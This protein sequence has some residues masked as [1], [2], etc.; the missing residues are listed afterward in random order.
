MNYALCRRVLH[1]LR[2]VPCNNQ[3]SIDW[4]YNDSISSAEV[5]R[6]YWTQYNVIGYKDIK[7]NVHENGRPD[8]DGEIP[9]IQRLERG[10]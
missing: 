7:W 6:G 4:N 5:I 9:V 10:K 1:H 8:K 3:Y 2:C